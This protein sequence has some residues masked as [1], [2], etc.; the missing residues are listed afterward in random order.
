MRDMRDY[1]LW[2]PKHELGMGLAVHEG[3][4][5]EGLGP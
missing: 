5:H 1:Q 2:C 4:M 3:F